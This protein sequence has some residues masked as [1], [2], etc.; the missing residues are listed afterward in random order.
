MGFLEERVQQILDFIFGKEDGEI[1]CGECYA[2]IE[3]FV[4][5]EL[6]GESPAKT[7]PATGRHLRRCLECREEYKILLDSLRELEDSE[8]VNF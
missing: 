1:K 3:K 5:L 8:G 6:R 4:E 7:M 2:Q